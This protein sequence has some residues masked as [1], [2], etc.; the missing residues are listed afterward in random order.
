LSGEPCK[1]ENLELIGTEQLYQ[2]KIVRCKDCGMK[3][4]E[5]DGHRE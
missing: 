5:K 2:R 3:L 4:I 1:H